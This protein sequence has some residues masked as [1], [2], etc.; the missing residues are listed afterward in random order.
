MMKL[1]HRYR[2]ILALVPMVPL[3]LVSACG[4]SDDTPVAESTAVT[5]PSSTTPDASDIDADA[6]E[7]VVCDLLSNDEIREATG[8]A[9]ASAEGNVMALPTCDWELAVGESAEIVGLPVVSVVLMPESDYRSRVDPLGDGLQEIDG[10]DYEVKFHYAA[11]NADSGIPDRMY[12][13]ALNGNQG[14]Q[15]LAGFAPWDSE[16]AAKSGL[17]DM[18][19][20]IFDRI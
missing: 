2:Q 10:L 17:L 6:D 5:Q 3:L 18:A 12:F 7:Q 1:P 14:I 9:V 13:F 8:F 20:K 19:D 16:E 15:I 11:G 4:G